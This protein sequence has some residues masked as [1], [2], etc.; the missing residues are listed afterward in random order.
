MMNKKPLLGRRDDGA[1]AT[2]FSSLV[3]TS[4]SKFARGKDGPSS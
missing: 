2:E 3:I 4:S 1:G